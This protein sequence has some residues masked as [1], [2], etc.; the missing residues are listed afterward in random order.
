MGRLSQEW[1]QIYEDTYKKPS[2]HDETQRSKYIDGYVWGANLAEILI[3]QMIILWEQRNK[4]IHVE[5][6]DDAENLRKEKLIEK[7]KELQSQQD[8]TRPSD[9]FLFPA[10]SKKFIKISTSTQISS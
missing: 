7:A 4:K 8:M 6:D 1:L 5:N 10:D 3:R 2:S 9:A